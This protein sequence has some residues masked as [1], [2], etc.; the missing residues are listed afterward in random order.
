MLF[1]I[2]SKGLLQKENLRQPFLSYRKDI[3]TL[4][5]ESVFPIR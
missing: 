1:W 4:K 5:R 3:A 2:R